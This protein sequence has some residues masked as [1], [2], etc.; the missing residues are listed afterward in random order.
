VGSVFRS[1][2]HGV[3]VYPIFYVDDILVLTEPMKAMLSVKKQ[4]SKMYTV[5]DLGEAEYF[6]GVKIERESSTVKLTQTSYVKSV[7]DRFGMLD[8][9][10]AQTPMSDPVSLIIRQPRTEAEISQI[11]NVPFREAIGSVFYL[12]VR[13]RPDIAVAVSI[14]SKHVQEQRPDH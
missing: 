11:K 12:A 7:L 1:I 9:K 6:L 10:P 13:T 3:V 4:L 2:V 14:L 8:C 5:K